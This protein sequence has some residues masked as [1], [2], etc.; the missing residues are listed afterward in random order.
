[1][2]EFARIKAIRTDIRLDG[3]WYAYKSVPGN[4]IEYSPYTLRSSGDK[5][6]YRYIG[7]YYGNNS[8][9]NGSESRTLRT[10]LTVTTHIPSV[11]LILSAK[12]E[13]S[14][15]RYTRTLSERADGSE[16][17]QVISDQSDI[18]SVTGESVYAGDNYVVRYPDWYCSYDDPTPRNY[19]EDLKAAKASGNMNLFNDLWQLSYKSNYLYMLG[20]DYYSPYFSANFSVTKEIGELASISFY[21]NNFFVN[22][23]QIWSTKTRTYLSAAS[24]IPKFY[25]GLTVRIKF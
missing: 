6:P 19:L 24:Y 20:K 17:A 14:L 5:L 18:L 4:M 15:L 1:M 13:A 22:R 9:S 12:V 7:C 2:V 25:Y 11:R 3:S 16:L 23:Q 21:A 8:Y 10:N